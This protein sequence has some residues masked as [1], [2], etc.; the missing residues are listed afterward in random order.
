MEREEFRTSGTSPDWDS[1]VDHS[2]RGQAMFFS[3]MLHFGVLV[4]NDLFGLNYHYLVRLHISIRAIILW[5]VDEW[6][7]T[8]LHRILTILTNIQNTYHHLFPDYFLTL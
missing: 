2:G 6:M 3:Q 7:D 8:N 4:W 5:V 1:A